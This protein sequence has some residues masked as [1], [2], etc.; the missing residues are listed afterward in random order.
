MTK[1]DKRDCFGNHKGKCTVLKEQGF[2][3]IN[4]SFY[5]TKE[6]AEKSRKKARQRLIDKDLIG[7]VGKYIGE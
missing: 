2:S 5:A 1:C 4:C 3:P 6:Q 7:L